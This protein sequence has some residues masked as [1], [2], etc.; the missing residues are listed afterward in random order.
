[1]LCLLVK[2]SLNVLHLVCHTGVK[3]LLCSNVT[4]LY[5]SPPLLSFVLQ[6]MISSLLMLVLCC[7][8][9]TFRTLW[10]ASSI[11]AAYI[12]L[13]HDL[14]ELRHLVLHLEVQIGR[15][16]SSTCM[17]ILITIVRRSNDAEN[18]HLRHRQ[19]LISIAINQHELVPFCLLYDFFSLLSKC[20]RLQGQ[21]LRC[22][23]DATGGAS[24]AL[25]DTVFVR[26]KR[27]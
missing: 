14:S 10:V 23:L 24:T 21:F 4:A 26:A 13:K 22:E 1:M 16:R 27:Q 17:F 9:H 2:R 15:W 25:L 8:V 11:F 3:S 20:C 18:K 5:R 12:E 7:R 19:V 6:L